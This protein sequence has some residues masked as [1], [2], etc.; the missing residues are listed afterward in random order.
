M[1]KFLI[2]LVSTLSALAACLVVK[3]FSWLL[4]AF[5]AYILFRFLEKN[6]VV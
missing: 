6:K 1:T 4:S 5:G 2:F 3:E